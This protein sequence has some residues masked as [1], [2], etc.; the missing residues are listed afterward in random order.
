MP[1][2]VLCPYFIAVHCPCFCRFSA[3][4]SLDCTGEEC[5]EPLPVASGFFHCCVW[6][7]A[8]AYLLNCWYCFWCFV[9]WTVMQR[10]SGVGKEIGTSSWHIVFVVLHYGSLW[11]SCCGIVRESLIQVEVCDD[12]GWF[13]WTSVKGTLAVLSTVGLIRISSFRGRWQ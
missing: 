8:A 3:I 7:K 12:C 13:G 9:L 1:V 11:F 10:C 5:L 6:S 2:R 4:Y